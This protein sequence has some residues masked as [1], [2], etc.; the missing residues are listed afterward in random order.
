[1]IEFA[2]GWTNQDLIKTLY[3][4]QTWVKFIR[5][6][7]WVKKSVLCIHCSDV[8]NQLHNNKSNLLSREI[9]IN[10]KN[11]IDFLQFLPEKRIQ[12]IG[13]S[14]IMTLDELDR[15]VDIHQ[16]YN[17]TTPC[18]AIVQISLGIRFNNLTDL[19][20][21]GKF[22]FK[23]KIC[24]C[25]QQSTCSPLKSSCFDTIEFKQ[26]KTGTS[27]VV[28][29]TPA[30]LKCFEQIRGTKAFSNGWYNNWLGNNVGQGLKSHGL[31]KL[32]PNLTL[33]H[34]NT[35]NWKSGTVMKKHYLGKNVAFWDFHLLLKTKPILLHSE[36]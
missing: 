23:R 6:H 9:N 31:R 33:G 36:K 18:W 22:S 16:N 15:L 11:K 19:S 3:D 10:L 21:K 7:R 30:A 24:R 34:R 28:P 32:I 35:G 25:E 12:N 5:Q 8:L 1:M 17:G 29:L 14:R 4:T 2:G 13:G 20:D 27:F 26:S